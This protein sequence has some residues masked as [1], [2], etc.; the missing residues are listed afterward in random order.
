MAFLCWFNSEYEIQNRSTASCIKLV[1]SSR[2]A[3]TCSGR[4]G[5]WHAASSVACN[6]NLA[7]GRKCLSSTDFKTSSFVASAGLNLNCRW[8]SGGTGFGRKSTM[9]SHGKARRSGLYFAPGSTDEKTDDQNSGVIVLISFASSNSRRR[10]WVS[11]SRSSRRDT[12]MVFQSSWEHR[13]FWE[14]ARTRDD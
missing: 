10:V 3:L 13:S 12:W 4:E 7:N 2:L 6:M 11:S 8:T 9:G 5:I 1:H 14:G